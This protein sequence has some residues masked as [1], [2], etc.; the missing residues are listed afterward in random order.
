MYKSRTLVRTILCFVMNFDAPPENMFNHGNISQL[1]S[2]KILMTRKINNGS[3]QNS[4]LEIKPLP[5]S[6]FFMFELN[7]AAAAVEL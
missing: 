7:S 4:K 2:I 3:S 5:R 1:N 6:S